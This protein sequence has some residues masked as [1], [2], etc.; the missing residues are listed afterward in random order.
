MKESDETP[1]QPLIPSSPNI[2]K[3][4]KAE[5]GIDRRKIYITNAVKHF[6]WEPA[7]KPIGMPIEVAAAQFAEAKKDSWRPFHFPKP[8][9]STIN[10][11][12]EVW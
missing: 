11:F 6:K 8:L 7:G 4:R 5:A 1:A 10:D 3:L 12:L 9:S 2:Q